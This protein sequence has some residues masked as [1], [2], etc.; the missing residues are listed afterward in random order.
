MS[1]SIPTNLSPLLRESGL[2]AEWT[3]SQNTM[4]AGRPPFLLPDP[5]AENA[6]WAGLEPDAINALQNAAARIAA[7]ADL[8]RLAWHCHHLL[9]LSETYERRNLRSWPMFV[10]LLGEHCGAFYLLIALSGL[11]QTRAFHRSRSVPD[12]V[13]RNTYGDTAIWARQYRKI[14]ILQNG[15]FEHPSRPGI[16]GISPRALSWLCNHLCGDLF[17]LERLQFIQRPYRSEFLAFRNRKTGRVH[18]LADGSIRFRADGQVDGT[19]GMADS[20]TGWTSR[21]RTQKDGVVGTPIHPEGRALPGEVVLPPDTWEPILSPGD[22]IL[23]IHI[24]EDGPMDFDA[25]GASF[26]KAVEFFPQHFPDRPF[27]A[28]CCTSWLLDPQYQTL[29]SGR[30]N[31]VRFQRECYLFPRASPGGRSGL[32]RIFGPHAK[33]LSTAP[34]DTRLRRAVLDHLNG[35]GHLKSG[36]ALIFPE[37]LNWGERVYL[38]A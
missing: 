4:A 24:P 38:E 23:E 6:G 15:G 16:W 21:L 25:C 18:L 28:F 3:A 37:D 34:R 29:L 36:G 9:F 20:K 10:D 8:T 5:I 11:P 13:A 19:G 32:E 27:R 17:R 2:D 30:S 12:R 14:G 33:D 1:S 7:D 26:R 22:P 35:G 31:I